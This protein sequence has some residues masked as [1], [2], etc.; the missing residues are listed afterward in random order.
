MWIFRLTGKPL[1]N[2]IVWMDARAECIITSMK[3]QVDEDMYLDIHK[4][5]L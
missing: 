5:N 3:G 2:A 4:R 1:Y